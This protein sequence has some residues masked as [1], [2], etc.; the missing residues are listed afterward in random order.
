MDGLKEI[1]S[2]FLALEEG[3]QALIANGKLVRFENVN[4]PLEAVKAG[5]FITR[6]GPF[7][8]R[9]GK[10]G[11]SPEFS[12][13]GLER[14]VIGCTHLKHGEI[15]SFSVFSEK[16]E[17]VK[18]SRSSPLLALNFRLLIE[19]I[20]NNDDWVMHVSREGEDYYSLQILTK[21]ND[22]PT[23]DDI[24]DEVPD[25][26]EVYEEP[27]EVLD[28]E[29]SVVPDEEPFIDEEPVED[30]SLEDSVIVEDAG[31]EESVIVPEPEVDLRETEED[32]TRGYWSPPDETSCLDIELSSKE[33][34]RGMIS[35]DGSQVYFPPLGHPFA[36]EME[37]DKGVRTIAVYIV[38]I[39]KEYVFEIAPLDILHGELSK[40]VDESYSLSASGRRSTPFKKF[41]KGHNIESAKDCDTFRFTYL[42]KKPF[43]YRLTPVLESREDKP[44]RFIRNEAA[45]T[46][47]SSLIKTN[48]NLYGGLDKTITRFI[49]PLVSD[50]QPGSQRRIHP[51]KE[52]L[53][54]GVVPVIMADVREHFLPEHGSQFLLLLPLDWSCKATAARCVDA[55][56]GYEGWCIETLPIEE[57]D[58]TLR[59]RV[60]SKYATENAVADFYAQKGMPRFGGLSLMREA[61]D[62]LARVYSLVKQSY[63]RSELSA[64][65]RRGFVTTL[66]E[67]DISTGTLMLHD[68]DPFPSKQFVIENMSGNLVGQVFRGDEVFPR[69]GLDDCFFIAQPHEIDEKLLPFAP[70]AESPE[71]NLGT[72][73][74]LFDAQPGVNSARFS[75]RRKDPHVYSLDICAN[76]FF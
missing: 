71:S 38:E 53:L 19:V 56:R 37:I 3:E 50:T 12:N 59:G 34:K 66:G 14:A 32:R 6:S 7:D 51:S 1:T 54:A 64:E 62:G 55:S 58:K 20:R 41:C 57:V 39:D 27:R 30:L 43:T 31:L 61:N 21:P 63:P 11:S 36:L 45:A 68:D 28:E 10:N 17:F 49:A 70:L 73:Y 13:E 4:D 72:I 18:Y 40:V 35:L 67:R 29:F 47:V 42:G 48:V 46:D 9:V 52:G 65:E 44:K 75:L 76:N 5:G 26:I 74:S 8:Y 2:C 69:E 60:N 33:L 24:V 22:V 25:K 16:P 15:G 23:V